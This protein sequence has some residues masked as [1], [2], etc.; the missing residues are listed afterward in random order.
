MLATV[1]AIVVGSGITG[2]WAAKELT[3]RGLTV[4]MI[5][6]G[7]P[8]E[9]GVDYKGEHK[10]PWEQAFRGRGDRQ[11]ALRD[12][13][14]NSQ[15]YAFSE[16][17]ESF[18]AKDKDVPYTHPEGKK[19]A[20]HRSGGFGGRSL[21]WGR[22]VYRLSDLDF[23]ANAQ[24]GHGVDWPIRYADIAP[25]YD[26]VESFIGVSG[27]AEGLP[28]LPDGRF[29]KPMQF[30]CAEAHV[31]KKIA[32]KF[33]DR[34]MTIGRVAVLTEPLGDRAACH[35]C[36]PCHQGCS[37][38][39][40]FSTQSST[41]PAAQATG[42]LT[43][44]TDT[45]VERIEYDA[46]TN[47]ATGVAVVDT[48]TGTRRIIGAGMLFLCASTIPTAQLLLHSTS[49][50][51]P[52]GFANSSG[53]VGRYLMDHHLGLS[54]M[55][56]LPTVRGS[57]EFGNRPNGIYVP[58]F[59]NLSGGESHPDFIR[60]YGY[61]GRGTQPGWE[62][63]L[64]LPGV[65]ADWK[66][67]LLGPKP[68]MMSFSG[69]GECLPYVTN[70]VTLDPARKD[71]W[72][73]PQPHIDM[74]WGENERVMRQDM[75]AEAKAMLEASGAVMIQ[76]SEEMSDPGAGIHEMG[77]ARMG[78][79]SATSALNAWNQTHDVPNVYV[80]DGSC[81]T[82]AAWQNPSLTWMALTARAAKHAAENVKR[83]FT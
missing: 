82:S 2:G 52:T 18:W 51:F 66:A 53:V 49:E 7:H 43:T 6:R 74:A 77:T 20:W 26:H 47:R 73:I 32:E 78:R 44:L 29:Q 8:V 59:R 10:A 14:R 45:L 3:E 40:Y 67:A 46:D 33:S 64:S 13:P 22:Q 19:F 39:S 54:G 36:G 5:E 69:F 83:K 56:L 76:T 60:G 4:L 63:G 25:W 16:G 81:M 57:E 11:A 55:G 24:D 48:K 12:Y 68:W 9:H 72:G 21:L 79:D 35:Y 23:A 38:G 17:N 30:N 41:L 70:R 80:T 31:R 50:S 61:Q 15:V 71:R 28:Q 75:A 62:M 27:Q 37:T 65:G 1:D 42:R 58:R 34:R